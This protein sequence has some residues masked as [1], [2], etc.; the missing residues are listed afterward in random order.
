ME[1]WNRDTGERL[2]TSSPVFGKGTTPL[3]ETDYM[4]SLPPCVWGNDP[5][6]YT[7][8]RLHLTSNLTVIK[9]A[10]NTYGHWGVMALWQ[11]RAAYL[12][13]VRTIRR[14]TWYV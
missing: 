7:P 1:L 5:S 12:P 14:P 8:P 3:N 11:M 9:V 4:I 13:K 6:L 2:C 10:N